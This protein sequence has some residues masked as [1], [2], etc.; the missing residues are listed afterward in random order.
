MVLKEAEDNLT[1]TPAI[2]C[3]DV[4]LLQTRLT[5]LFL[6]DVLTVARFSNSALKDPSGKEFPSLATKLLSY[7]FSNSVLEVSPEGHCD[8][9][10][11][12]LK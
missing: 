8:K 10:N 4:K 5:H 7:S 2:I 12:P 3:S 6:E 11:C 9:E 1:Y